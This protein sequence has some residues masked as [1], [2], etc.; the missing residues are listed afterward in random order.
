ML[1]DQSVLL[2]LNSSNCW[3]RVV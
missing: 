2:L 3:K 1:L